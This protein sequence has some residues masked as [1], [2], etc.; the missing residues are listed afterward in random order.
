MSA[1]VPPPLFPFGVLPASEICFAFLDEISTLIALGVVRA[2]ASCNHRIVGGLLGRSFFPLALG[3]NPALLV[4]HIERV[5]SSIGG[6]TIVGRR[7]LPEGI[8]ASPHLTSV[9]GLLGWPRPGRHGCPKRGGG[10]IRW[11]LIGVVDLPV[12]IGPFV[13]LLRRGTR[14][15]QRPNEQASDHRMTEA[16][17]DDRH[18][19]NL[20]QIWRPGLPTTVD[21]L[22]RRTPSGL[23]GC[24]TICSQTS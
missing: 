5:E 14:G 18:C 7:G 1:A 24:V 22:P 15:V 23:R 19:V 13:D 21:P 2:L 12:R 20:T 16:A 10:A 4:V 8:L 6:R 17:V 3:Q 9:F 11:R